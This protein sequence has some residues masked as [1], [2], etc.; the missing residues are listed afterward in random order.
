M[1]GRV[2]DRAIEEIRARIDIVEL[3]GARGVALKRAGASF[4]GCCP[5]HREKTPSF[6]VNPARQF[7]HCFGCQEHGDVFTFV[8]KQEGLTFIEAVRALAEKAGVTLD[9]AVDYEAES[10][11]RL[12]A[13]HLELAAF[14]QRCLEQTAGA[15]PARAYLESRKLPGDI[16]KRFGIG[17]APLRRDALLRWAEKHGFTPEELVAAGVL[18]PPKEAARQDDYF[19]RFRG[20]LMFPITD[21]QGRV[22]AFSGRVLDPKTH[23]AKYVNSPETPVFRKS[24][25]LYALDKARAAIVKHPRREAVVCEGQIDVIRCHAAGIDTAVAS[26]GTAF[27]REHV[28]L[29]KRHADSAVLLFDGDDA[30]RKAAVRTG[31]L[32]LEAGLPVR[33]AALP[34]GEDPDSLIRDRGGDAARALIAAAESLVA[35]QIATLR[36]GEERPDAVD[37]F[38]RVSRGVIETLASCA[39]A[40]LRSHLQQEAAGMLN[41]PESALAEEVETLR[42]NQAEAAA[43]AGSFAKPA[44][45]AHP[46]PPAAPPDADGAPL[47]DPFADGETAADTPGAVPAAAAEPPSPAERALAELLFQHED[48]PGIG[49]LLRTFLPGDAL[50]HPHVRALFRAWSA[51]G[52]AGGDALG[53]LYAHADAE[54][55]AFL[56]PVIVHYRPLTHGDDVSPLDAAREIVARFWID[57]LRAERDGVGRE[58]SET[59]AR[60]RLDLT[61]RIKLLQQAPQEA[62]RRSAAHPKEPVTAWSLREPVLREELARRADDG[63]DS[64]Q[65][66]VIGEP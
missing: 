57:M 19:D 46:P 35:F 53:E 50:C 17:Y 1:S 2:T 38:S 64:E 59:A 32:F 65:G 47:G 63:K 18:L 20:R 29:L 33:V 27:T 31:V 30:G 6:H 40:V 15:A 54:L 28:D 49:A 7:Y 39:S 3:I 52:G 22:V 36:A 48:D 24:K 66:S 8:M 21:V 61:R 42:R 43:R 45:A 10:R 4:K 41:L 58:G 5:F 62:E 55:R 56:D 51:A 44:A 25:I 60:R 9:T 14:Y 11:N 12:Y 26:Q 23:P 34:P 16:V 37:A 13:L